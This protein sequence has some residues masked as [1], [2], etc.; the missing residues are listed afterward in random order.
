MPDYM[1]VNMF[2]ITN[3]MNNLNDYSL[4]EQEIL[5]EG[6][7]GSGD[8]TLNQPFTNFPFIIIVYSTDSSN[9]ILTKFFSTKNLDYL[10]RTSDL[11]VGIADTY[12]YWYIQPYAKGT[13]TKFFKKS[14]EN[15]SI[16]GIYGLKF[17]VV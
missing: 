10:L 15:T 13:T 8:I 9:V 1:F 14:T 6:I 2:R 4:Y 16:Y 3:I 5:F 7:Q 11:P 12:K 17:P